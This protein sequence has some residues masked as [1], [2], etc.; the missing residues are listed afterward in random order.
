MS[1]IEIAKPTH[2]LQGTITINIG[3]AS[4]SLIGSVA[5]QLYG[6]ST[7]LGYTI[8]SG[9]NPGTLVLTISGAA[10]VNTLTASTS[11]NVVGA[12]LVIVVYWS[13]YQVNGLLLG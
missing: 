8:T 10:G 4:A 9:T 2:T 12:N 6:V 7:I 13:N 5:N 3:S 11:A 1:N